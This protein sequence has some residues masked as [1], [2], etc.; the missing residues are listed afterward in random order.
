MP[1]VNLRTMS[2]EPLE[3]IKIEVEFLINNSVSL[4]P[5]DVEKALEQIFRQID[6]DELSPS[7]RYRTDIT[8]KLSFTK[9]EIWHSYAL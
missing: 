7:D 1:Q 2:T 8:T 3:K 4:T 6:T 9:T 5:R